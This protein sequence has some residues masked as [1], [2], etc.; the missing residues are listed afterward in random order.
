MQCESYVYH[1]GGYLSNYYSSV[2]V[3]F[4]LKRYVRMHVGLFSIELRTILPD[5]LKEIKNKVNDLVAAMLKQTSYA[6]TNQ[7]SF[8]LKSYHKV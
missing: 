7:P 1:I 8:A 5:K 6:N 4:L 3:R 2:P